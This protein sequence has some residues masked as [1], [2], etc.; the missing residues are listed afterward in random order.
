MGGFDAQ[1]RIVVVEG[2]SEI[3]LLP[4]PDSA[5]TSDSAPFLCLVEVLLGGPERRKLGGHVAV[6]T[7]D[8]AA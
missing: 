4:A 7:A 2:L 6:A 8:C 1:A 5:E 3:G